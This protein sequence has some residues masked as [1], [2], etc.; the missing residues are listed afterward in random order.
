MDCSKK[1]FVNTT[2]SSS[3][4][5][6]EELLKTMEH[7]LHPVTGCPWDRE[8][9][10]QSLL[11]YLFEESYEFEE[12][13][14]TAIDHNDYRGMKEELGD[15]LLQILLHSH[16]AQEKG[17]FNFLDVCQDLK[18][19]LITRHPHVSFQNHDHSSRSATTKELTSDE[20]VK[21]WKSHKPPE[22]I[23]QWGR[24]ELYA[25]ALESAHKI[26]ER[27]KKYSF[28]WEDHQQVLYKV[29]E[30]WQEVKEELRPYQ[31]FDVKKVEEELGDLLFSIVQLARHLNIN[32]EKAL[33]KGNQKFLNRFRKML[34]LIQQ[35]QKDI[36]Q[37][38]SQQ[39]EYYWSQAKEMNY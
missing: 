38:S 19:K 33:K 22:E 17:H 11:P 3:L 29:E 15:L 31:S 6:V 28:D 8:Q 13:V 36:H 4:S 20:V 2:H 12:S 18:E 30:E 16:K 9:T 37:L 5:S 34:G 7:L 24:K 21:Q 25:T 35:D 1:P 14:T 27:S 23:A 10:H 32:T 26:G 39:K